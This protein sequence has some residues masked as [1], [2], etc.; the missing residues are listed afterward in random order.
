MRE[1]NSN[2]CCSVSGLRRVEVCYDIFKK[3][4]SSIHITYDFGATKA[5]KKL[6]LV[7]NDADF[8]F[9]DFNTIE[10]YFDYSDIGILTLK[11]C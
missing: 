5:S 9:V 7:K 4:R 8:Y 3:F 2:Y 11:L 6:S 1:G 10:K